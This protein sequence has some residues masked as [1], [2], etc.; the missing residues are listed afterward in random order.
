MVNDGSK[1]LGPGG[2]PLSTLPP[3]V[4][5]KTRQPLSQKLVQIIGVATKSNV[6]VL[7]FE[8]DLLMGKLAM[9]DIEAIH[10]A[11][12]KVLK[13]GKVEELPKSSE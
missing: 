9:E 8:K 2:L 13:I 12:H 6:V 4:V 3:I 7:P 1:L 10:E 11:I 5:I